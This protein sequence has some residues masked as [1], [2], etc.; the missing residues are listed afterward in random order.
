MSEFQNKL[1]E[2]FGKSESLDDVLK[3]GIKEGVKPGP[4]EAQ[5]PEVKPEQQVQEETQAV[6]AETQQEEPTETETETT[7]ETEEEK[8]NQAIAEAEVEE[9][10]QE[11]KHRD[12]KA[13]ARIA[14]LVKERERLRGQ[15]DAIRQEQQKQ[16]AQQEA[17]IDPD[18]PNPANYPEGD[19]DID[20]RVDVKLYQREMQQKQATFR[21]QQQEMIK[22]YPDMQ[23]LLEMDA[24]RVRSGIKTAN[25]TVVKLI[26]ESDLSGDLWHYLLA[27]SDE[28]IRI[29]QMDPLQTARE[30]GKIESKIATPSLIPEAKPVKKPLPAPI[31]P[32]KTTKPN[33]V[34]GQKNFGFSEY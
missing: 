22:K 23:E 8:E 28:A 14:K 21:T 18:A 25:P 24:E 3:A 15:L 32:L 2:A 17:Y 16:P 6:E 1:D 34:A 33:A 5:I 26:H 12:T 29:A 31:T 11:Q 20:Y 30:I 10:Q 13:E 9:T 7:A 4:G 27:N 19:K